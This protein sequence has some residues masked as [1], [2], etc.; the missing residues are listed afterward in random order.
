M[1]KARI[2]Y[3]RTLINVLGSAIDESD[4]KTLQLLLGLKYSKLWEY[5]T[6]RSVISYDILSVI[7]IGKYQLDMDI[8]NAQK[9]IIS[10]YFRYVDLN[11]G[12]NPHQT[13]SDKA[14]K[15][16][17][18]LKEAQTKILSLYNEYVSASTG[19][20]K[21][22][23]AP[24]LIQSEARSA[25]KTVNRV[26]SPPLNW[27]LN[28]QSAYH[29]LGAVEDDGQDSHLQGYPKKRKSKSTKR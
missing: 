10:L 17:E 9:S 16:N 21:N 29:V 23:G 25:D 11:Q 15:I 6:L 28:R 3:K 12:W 8:A 4:I 14:S 5:R 1:H 24:G 22:S 13:I 19:G 2:V 18:E 7:F 26:L 27:D 20:D